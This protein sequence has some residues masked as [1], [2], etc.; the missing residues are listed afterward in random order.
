MSDLYAKVFA[1]FYDRVAQKAEIEA[2][3]ERRKALISC[4]KGNV[5]EIGAGTGVNF[6]F[7]TKDANVL[8]IEP[9]PYMLRQAKEK[10][11]G[12]KNI[13]LLQTSVEL[14]Y[15][16]K[17]VQK[18]SLDAMVCTL[19]LCTIPDPQKALSYFYQWLKPDGVLIIIEHIKAHEAWKGKVQDIL[20]P[21]WKVIGEGC[22]LNRKTDKM[23][24]Q[25]GFQVLQ[26]DY[27][28]YKVLWYQGVFSKGKVS[29]EG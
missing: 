18:N 21:V 24:R 17:V 9:S 19:V 20:N 13:R 12:R 26:E 8:A 2:L 6:Q 7:Y 5:L 23:I 25:A 29:K 27:F 22:H 28:T 1:R 4:L 16:N 10:K 3:A 14:C 11:K 15:E